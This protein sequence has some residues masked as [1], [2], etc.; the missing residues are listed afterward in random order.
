[1]SS[2]TL[3][4]TDDG[5]ATIRF[6]RRLRHPVEAVWAALTDPAQMSRW[7]GDCEVDLRVGGTFVVRWR[8]QH[9]G[10]RS[11]MHATITRLDPPRLLE[12]DGD[13]HGVLRWE[14]EPE[15]DGGTRL[16]FSSTLEL[17]DEF[18]TEVLA[19]WH[20]HLDALAEALDGGE[21]DLVDLPGWEDVHR[22]Y[23]SAVT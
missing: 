15:G 11:V 10:R 19:G 17:P 2:G 5:T 23:A 12:T 16:T 21:A 8:N 4:Q 22:G 6:V 18:R 20:W 3:E 9:E 1:M 7:W 13:M 14:L